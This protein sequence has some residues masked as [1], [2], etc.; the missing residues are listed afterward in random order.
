[1]SVVGQFL[2]WIETARVSERSDAA[3]SLARAYIDGIF[4][5]EEHCAAGAALT[6][7]LDDPSPKVR[8]ALAEALSESRQAPP[9]VIAALAVDQAEI[10]ALVLSRSPLLSDHDLIEC[11]A[12]NPARVQAI[13]AAR[14]RIAVPL[15]A[16]IA[17]I[18]EQPACL[19]LLQNQSS[20]IA[21]ISYRRLVERFGDDAEIRVALIDRGD[22]PCDCRH[23]LIRALGEILL[24]SPLLANSLGVARLQRLVRDSCITATITLIDEVEHEDIPALVEH[25][26]LR[27][28]LTTSFLIR[29]VTFGKV[30][31]FGAVL[32]ALSGQSPRHVQS[33][34]SRGRSVAL[35]SLLKASGIATSLHPIL[36]QALQMWRDIAQGR[37]VAGVQE[38]SYAMLNTLQESGLHELTG[39]MRRIHLDALRA[40]AKRH[41]HALL[42]EAE[43]P[44]IV[45]LDLAPNDEPISF[46]Q[47]AA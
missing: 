11:L 22:L 43:M 23:Q 47:E 26:R 6:V 36:V 34:L 45:T 32:V 20:N 13:I 40:N 4:E 30:D 21:D 39:F 44:E 3:G 38:V 18:A 10:A 12:R 2:K 41:A 29:A 14:K 15:A 5:F 9:Q 37:R 42:R 1:M 16:A 19:V 28:D 33:L 25:L 46:E 35:S 31:F 7:L 17:E 8:Y 27:G 24:S